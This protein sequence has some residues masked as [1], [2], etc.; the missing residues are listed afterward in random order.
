[1]IM[2][3]DEGARVDIE[4]S[5]KIIDTLDGVETT[6]HAAYYGVAADYYKVHWI[7]LGF[8]SRAHIVASQ[9]K[10]RLCEI[11]QK[12]T[13]LPGMRGSCERPYTFRKINACSRP[14]SERNAR[15]DH[16]QLRRIG[17]TAVTWIV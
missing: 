10:S 6:V 4:E 1:M 11:L 15:G 9:D 17:Q 5:S 8:T 12:L 2:G 7:L 3:D 13:P 14:W 16:L